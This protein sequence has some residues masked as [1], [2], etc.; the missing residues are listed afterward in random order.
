MQRLIAVEVVV[1][2]LDAGFLLEVLDRVRRDVIGPVVD[3]EDLL[4]LAQRRRA[5]GEG[6]CQGQ[7]AGARS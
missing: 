1:P 5:K 3:V 4:L 7:A 2:D 6:G